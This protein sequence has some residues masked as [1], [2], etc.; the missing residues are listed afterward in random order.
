MQSPRIKAVDQ[1]GRSKAVGAKQFR[2]K[3]IK[4][5]AG[6]SA[7]TGLPVSVASLPSPNLASVP[8]L[9]DS[10]GAAVGLLVGR[11]VV[12]TGGAGDLVLG[13]KS[14][15]IA[16]PVGKHRSSPSDRPGSATRGRYVQW[17]NTTL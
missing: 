15:G 11:S 14:R 9:A 5:K 12:K 3:S 2:R 6:T 17:A 4:A 16:A 7:N 8:V 13:L 10:P 1:S